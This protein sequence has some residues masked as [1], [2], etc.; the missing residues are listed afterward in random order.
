MPPKHPRTDNDSSPFADTAFSSSPVQPPRTRQRTG[1]ATAAAD[2]DVE[3]TGPTQPTQPPIE[4]TTAAA[5]AM[6]PSKKPDDGSKANLILVSNRLPLTVKRQGDGKYDFSMSSGG[7]VTGI[8]G[9]AKQVNF[10]WYGWPGLEVPEQERKPMIDSLAKDFSAVPVFLSKDDIDRHYNGFSNSILWPLLH[11]HPSDVTFDEL[12]WQAYNRVNREF[13][14]TMA[15]NVQDGDIVWVHDYH[16][17]VL[18]QMLREE[19]GPERKNV[20]IGFFLHTPFPSS[21]MFRILPVPVREGILKSLLSCDLVGFHT[22]D[23]A[24]HF[25]SSCSRILGVNTLP[26]GAEL[27]GRFVTVGAF[28][29]GI[30]VTKFE[31]AFQNPKV[32]DRIQQLEKKFAGVSVVVGVDRLDYI[33]GMPQKLHS[34]ELF[35]TEHPEWVGKIVLVQVAVPSRQDVDEYRDLWKETNELVGRIN[36]KFGTVEYMPIHW[37]Y[38][39]VSFEE[40]TALYAVSDV[41]LVTSTRDGMNLVSYEYVAAQND[42]HGVLILSEFAGAAQSLNGS[43]IINPWNT[44]DVAKAIYT[45]VTMPAEQRDGNFQKLRRYV[46]QYTSQWWGQSFV[47]ELRAVKSG[48]Q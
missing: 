22:Y 34:F 26:N 3:V 36:G 4:S 2:E 32:L 23:Y 9:M 8:M 29:I 40:M 17:F 5:S 14:K 15:Q 20:R 33:K 19:L 43:L 24:R 21:E 41:C 25:L 1:S 45:A 10:T 48:D 16:H 38:H 37:L 6:D 28:P 46:Y 39:S 44:E 30:D 12:S 47:S 7:L 18:P 27:N 13:A 35:L 31:D 42:R 11:Y